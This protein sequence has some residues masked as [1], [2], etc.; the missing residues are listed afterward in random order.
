MFERISIELNV[1]NNIEI[2]G[3]EIN[4]FQ[5]WKN[6]LL[7]ASNLFEGI[8]GEKYIRISS[9]LRKSTVFIEINFNG[10]KISDETISNILDVTPIIDSTNKTIISKLSMIKKIITE[11]RGVFSIV[12]D[13]ST[14][15]YIE[16]PYN[17][18][19]L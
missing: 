1:D 2:S 19:N 8:N 6:A 5:F 14:F 4:L 13:E 3:S 9:E 15:L 17:F 18:E 11:H 12:S 16:L 7:L 10:K